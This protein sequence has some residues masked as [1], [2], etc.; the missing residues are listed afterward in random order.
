MKYIIEKLRKSREQVCPLKQHFGV[1]MFE[2]A[3]HNHWNHMD[4][5]V[6][7]SP[8]TWLWMISHFT[9]GPQ[10]LKWSNHTSCRRE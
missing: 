1:K 5:D 9:S 2:S 8:T 6:N 10:P 3:Q 4:I 7:P